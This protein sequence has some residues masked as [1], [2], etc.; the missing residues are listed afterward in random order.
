M[1]F[2]VCF[3]FH[4]IHLAIHSVKIGYLVCN[5]FFHY[6]AT[7]LSFA[8]R[9][10]LLCISSKYFINIF[11]LLTCIMRFLMNFIL[12]LISITSHWSCSCSYNMFS[13]SF[14][15][16]RKVSS[17]TEIDM[18]RFYVFT[19]LFFKLPSISL[20]FRHF[21]HDSVYVFQFDSHIHCLITCFFPLSSCIYFSVSFF[22]FSCLIRNLKRATLTIS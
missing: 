12:F 19:M 1:Y 6:S 3:S 17:G 10:F 5:E 16:K 9:A 7:M 13:K 15:R 21:S 2:L 11:T 20:C 22:C 14:S 8:F 18:F 4:I